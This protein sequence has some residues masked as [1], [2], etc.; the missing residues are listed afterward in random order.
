[1]N[2]TFV[3]TSHENSP[4]MIFSRGQK[5]QPIHW[6]EQF[7]MHETMSGKAPVILGGH[8]HTVFEEVRRVCSWLG[9]FFLF[10]VIFFLAKS[11]YPSNMVHQKF[12]QLKKEIHLPSTSIFEFKMLIF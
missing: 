4:A 7:E 6:K 1:M 9:C 12:A 11:T 3:G 8:E 2:D 10:G 5:P